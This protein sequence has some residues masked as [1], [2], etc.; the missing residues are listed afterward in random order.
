MPT[1][2]LMG[3]G[4]VNPAVPLMMMVIDCPAEAEKLLLVSEQLVPLTALHV[5]V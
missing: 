2:Q 1:T 5:T 4:A 3:P